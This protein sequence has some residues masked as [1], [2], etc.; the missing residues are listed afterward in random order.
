MACGVSH[1]RE[2]YMQLPEPE[3]SLQANKNTSKHNKTTAKKFCSLKYCK[4]KET[5]NLEVVPLA[6][7]FHWDNVLDNN[8]LKGEVY[9]Q[10]RFQ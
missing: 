1:V 4:H 10:S 2:N 3:F 6:F 7:L 8:N 5:G 9:F